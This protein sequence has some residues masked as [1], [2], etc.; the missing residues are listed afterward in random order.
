[1]S[2]PSCGLAQDLEPASIL[3]TF[4][5]LPRI[6]CEADQEGSTWVPWLLESHAKGKCAT[7]ENKC[8]RNKEKEGLDY[9]SG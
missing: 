1:M 9:D 2:H 7:T 6:F 8:L 5:S 3:Q 4:H